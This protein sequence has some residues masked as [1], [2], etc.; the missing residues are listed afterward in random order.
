MGKKIRILLTGAAGAV[1]QETL[2]ELIKHEDKYDIIAF[3]KD[4]KEHHYILKSC[5]NNYQCVFGDIR[6][7]SV[8]DKLAENIDFVIHLAAV[9]PPLADKKPEL[10]RQVNYDGTRN[11]IESIKEKSPDAFF[12]FTSSVAVYGDRL[13]SP[14]I[15]TSDELIASRGDEYAKTKISAEEMLQN[16]GLRWSI[17]RLTAIMHPAQKFDPLMFHMPLETKMEICTTGDTAKALAKSVE[18]QTEIESRIFNLSGGETCRI[19]YRDFLSRAFQASGLGK[20][21]FPDEAFAKDNFHCGYYG[22]ANELENILHFRNDSIDDYLNQFTENLGI[23]KPALAR[24]F[25]P[26]VIKWFLNRSDRQTHQK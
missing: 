11:L 9:I 19:I 5:K 22:D 12:L 3:G 17:F 18:H 7:K 16:S 21:P 24:V 15:K 23:I 10:A 1:G 13:K 6:D 2:R 25:R 20:K 26:F 8:T 4:K 14:I